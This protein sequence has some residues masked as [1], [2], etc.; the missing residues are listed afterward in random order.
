MYKKGEKCKPG[1]YRPVSLTRII[2]KLME[3]LVRERMIKY[4]QKNHVISNQQHGFVSGRLTALQLIWVLGEWTKILDQGGEIDI[5]YMDFIWY[6][7][8]QKAKREDISIHLNLDKKLPEWQE[9]SCM[10]VNG[11]TSSKRDVTS[12]VPQGSVL[13]LILFVLYINDLPKEVQ[14]EVYLF[15]DDTRA[16]KSKDHQRLQDLLKLQEWSDKWLLNFILTSVW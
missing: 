8:T 3:K 14:S 15:A 1:N 6:S 9:T 13:G 7:S 2:C 5:I 16:I 10:Y 12:G 11:Q 4:L